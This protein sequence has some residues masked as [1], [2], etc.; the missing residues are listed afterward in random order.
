MNKTTMKLAYENNPEY[1]NNVSKGLK[2]AWAEGK[3]DTVDWSKVGAKGSKNK[4]KGTN[5]QSIL[6][7]SSRTASKII[8]RLAKEENIGCCICGWNKS[9]CD[10]HH[11]N[12]KKIE[13]ADEHS[14]LT[15]ICPNC[16][17][18]VHNGLIDISKLI[19]L[20]EHIGNKWKKYYFG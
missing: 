13:N 20:N 7:V 18:M 9:T 3:Y 4:Y 14:N 10:I 5:I 2:K 1:A 8:Q 15:L 17:R 6:C 16:H 19:P 12:G 11:I